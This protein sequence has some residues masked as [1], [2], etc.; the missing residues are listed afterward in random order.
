MI[1]EHELSVTSSM[2]IVV[3]DGREQS[4]EE[5]IRNADAAMYRAKRQGIPYEVFDDGMRNRVR[6]R[7]RTE[8]DLAARGRGA[9]VPAS[10]P[11]PGRPAQRRDRRASRR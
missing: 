4:A 8:S 3:S 7:A 2:G 10:V 6:A 1:D 11:A 5:L 9:R